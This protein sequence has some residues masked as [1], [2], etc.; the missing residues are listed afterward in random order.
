MFGLNSTEPTELHFPW[1]SA[2][3]HF[4]ETINDAVVP[5]FHVIPCVPNQPHCWVD[6]HV[7]THLRCAH[8]TLCLGWRLRAS[9][10]ANSVEPG[11]QYIGEGHS[12]T[13]F[14]QAMIKCCTCTVNGFFHVLGP[15]E[16]PTKMRKHNASV[17]WSRKHVQPAYIV[18]GFAWTFSFRLEMSFV[19]LQIYRIWR[20]IA[21]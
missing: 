20:N 15:I 1:K 9:H 8:S 2:V 10:N 17:Y 21:S 13:S 12:S 5:H 6:S 14:T 19:T 11:M 4:S 16:F 18:H 3:S 7:D